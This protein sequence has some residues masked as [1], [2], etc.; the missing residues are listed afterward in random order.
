MMLDATMKKGDLV[1]LEDHTYIESG[2][3]AIKKKV[4]LY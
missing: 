1:V 3:Y 2:K 4:G